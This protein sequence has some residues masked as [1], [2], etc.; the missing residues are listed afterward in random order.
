MAKVLKKSLLICTAAVVMCGAL[1]P[2]A[3]AKSWVESGQASNQIEANLV[4]GGTLVLKSDTAFSEVRV[5]DSSVADIVV[6]SDKSFQL[7]GKDRGKTSVMI[8]DKQGRLTDVIEINVGYD[9]QSL[10]KSLYESFPKERIEVRKLA[11]QIYMSGNVSSSRIAD[12]AVKIAQA[13]GGENV[14]SGL[15]VRD[16]HQ[17]M[18]EVRFV[19]ANRSAIKELGVGLLIQQAGQFSMTSGVGTL[20][21]APAANALMQGV[22]G[23]TSIDMSIHA[24]EE[25]GVM[26]T[27]AEPNLISMSGETASFLAG[28]EFPIPVAG[29]NGEIAITYRQFGVG[30]S[31]TPLV[32]DDGIIH[33]K[34]SPEVSQLDTTNS[35]RVGGV[36]V[37]SLSI[38]RADTTIELRNGQSFAIAG[39]LQNTQ[40]DRG[41]QVPWLGDIPILGTLFRSSRY[42]KNETEL[43]II[44]TPRLVQP[45]SDI[46]ELA[47]PL[48]GVRTPSEMEF[49]LNGKQ[50]GGVSP[51]GSNTAK[52]SFQD[53]A[54]TS[55]PGGLS[56]SYGH[57]IQ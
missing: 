22:V 18:L 13:Y 17:V 25:K 57:S 56:A 16:S 52:S 2:Q 10:K 30:L 55:A 1:A 15:T 48:D 43:V 26:R 5:V 53:M 31:F 32:L 50:D 49:F 51:S 9:I 12:Q 35:V 29:P 47:T 19:E 39:L 36:E 11:D 14:T 42:K 27:L 4:K 20:G 28:G 6:L 38:R 40:S 7:R 21:G 24:L 45:V 34:V 8:Y 41:V 37:P 54:K 3:I 44:V 46:R 33:L 23:A